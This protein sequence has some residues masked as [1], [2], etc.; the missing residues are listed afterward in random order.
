[1]QGTVM[2]AAELESAVRELRH[3]EGLHRRYGGTDK[4]FVAQNT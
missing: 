4:G 2:S 3:C 1:M